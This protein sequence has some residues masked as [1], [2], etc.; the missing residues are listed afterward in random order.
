MKLIRRFEYTYGT[1]VPPPSH[2][3]IGNQISYDAFVKV[4]IAQGKDSVDNQVML[5]GPAIRLVKET[6]MKKHGIV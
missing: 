4:H 1:G 6:L 2:D 5:L 3:I